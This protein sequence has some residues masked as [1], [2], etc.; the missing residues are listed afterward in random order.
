MCVKIGASTQ[1]HRATE[2]VQT[3]GHRD[4]TENAFLCG[5]R[6]WSLWRRVEFAGREAASLARNHRRKMQDRWVRAGLVFSVCGFARDTFGANSTRRPCL[7]VDVSVLR[8]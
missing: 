8:L 6:E 4:Y 5:V 3:P 1:S 7:C 2:L